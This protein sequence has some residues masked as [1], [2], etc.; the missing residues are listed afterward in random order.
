MI[1]WLASYPKSGNT[2]VRLFIDSLLNPVSNS[3]DIN[4]I[5]IKQFPLRSHFDGLDIDID[6]VGEFVSNCI[7]AQDKINLDKTV[8]IFKTHNAFWK[9]GPHAFTNEKNT[10]GV[11]HIVRDPRNVITSV[12][13][14]FS[15]EDYDEAFKI[16]TNSKQSIGSK[17]KNNDTDLPTVISSWSNHYNSWKKMK[18][19]YLQIKYE[20]LVNN[21][22]YEFGKI[23]KY[24]NENLNKYFEV[25]QINQ[26]IRNCNFENLKKQEDE[27]GFKESSKDKK[28]NIKKFFHLGPKNNWKHILDEK[29]KENI[30]KVFNN[31]MAE[32]GYL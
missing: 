25:K 30:E 20:N 5:K 7:V 1:I 29:T 19:N 26:A 15:T 24:L 8:K 22:E 14:H 12:M 16:M 4:N 28:G 31:E 3:I 17:I 10:K 32:L 18:K 27:K 2:W 13:N 6:N 21:P 23:A 11:I 9:S